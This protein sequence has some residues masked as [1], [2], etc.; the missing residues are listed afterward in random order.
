MALPSSK[1]S[2]ERLR[3][4]ARVGA[5]TLL[6]QLRAEIIAV[7]RTFPDLALPRKRRAVAVPSRRLSDVLAR[8]PMPPAKPSRRV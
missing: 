7:E 2:A 6:N 8:R 5:E 1:L 3:G 4:F